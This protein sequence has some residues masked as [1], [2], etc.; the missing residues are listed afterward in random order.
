M[1]SS[2]N[3][4]ISKTALVVIAAVA[5]AIPFVNSCS[6]Q[7]TYYNLKNEKADGEVKIAFLS[8]VHSSAYG[9][10]MSELV[11]AVDEFAPEVVVFGGDL[12]DEV[13]TTTNSAVLVE[14]LVAK[15]PCYYSVGNHEYDRGDARDIK[16]MMKDMGVTVLEGS[17]SDITINGTELRF[18]G[19]DG[20]AHTNHLDSVKSAVS[21]ER[22]NILLNHYP[23][24]FPYL[25]DYGFDYILSGHA[26]GGQ[27]R[28]PFLD[29][30]VYAPGQGLLPKYTGGLYEENGT[31][32]VLSRGLYR[33]LSCV[34]I[35]RVFNRPEAVF[36]T[37]SGSNS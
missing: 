30:G 4:K 6:L 8:D 34:I 1:K 17:Y 21:D 10:R 12:F 2:K 31:V 20:F 26:H 9:N 29:F 16:N 18:M 13:H 25:N 3:K 32:M 22:V 23:E 19:I 5:V 33:N 14:K 7:K 11:E 36:I 28:I 37:I 27:V 15:Y 24:E 35:P